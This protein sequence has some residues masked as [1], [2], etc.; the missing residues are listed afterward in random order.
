MLEESNAVGSMTTSS[1]YRREQARKSLQ[2]NK[3]ISSFRKIFPHLVHDEPQKSLEPS[4]PAKQEKVI[5]TTPARQEESKNA[6]LIFI[7]LIALST[8]LYKLFIT[9]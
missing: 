2:Y 6:I 7:L 5:S 8:I 3:T 4:I 1:S 9:S